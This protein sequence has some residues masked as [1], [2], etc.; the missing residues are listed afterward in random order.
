ML[1]VSVVVVLFGLAVSGAA[2][3]FLWIFA[4]PGA[5]L[6]FLWVFLMFLVLL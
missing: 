5:A 3:L 2:R 1:S 6:L 4:V